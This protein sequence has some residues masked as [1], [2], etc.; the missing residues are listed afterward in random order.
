MARFAIVS[1]T[2]A[3]RFPADSVRH[4]ALMSFVK[5]EIERRHRALSG[6]WVSQ[7][8]R[9]AVGTRPGTLVNKL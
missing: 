5:Q 9:I 2:R 6:A 7:M 3:T 1:L 4:G 8:A